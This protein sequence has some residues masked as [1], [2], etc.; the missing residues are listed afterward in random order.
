MSSEAVPGTV[1][2][3]QWSS[4][5]GF[6]CREPGMG[7]QSS[8]GGSGCQCLQLMG[9]PA[10]KTKSETQTLLCKGLLESRHS[11]AGFPGI[12]S[13]TLALG[14]AGSQSWCCWGRA[15]SGHGEPEFC[16][17]L[18]RQCFMHLKPVNPTADIYNS[19]M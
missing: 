3:A 12:H 7:F 17:L 1:S 16:F 18:H 2:I 14:Q 8:F 19:H 13:R 5:P 6:V 9:K 10:M 4:F 15:G 11:S